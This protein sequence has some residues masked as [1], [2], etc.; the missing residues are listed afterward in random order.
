MDDLG[1]DDNVRDDQIQMIQSNNTT[2]YFNGIKHYTLGRKEKFIRLSK[3][4]V[5]RNVDTPSLEIA[6]KAGGR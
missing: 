3:C 4:M 2:L 6:P 5:G 1:C